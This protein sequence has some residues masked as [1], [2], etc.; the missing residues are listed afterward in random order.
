MFS[1]A[2]LIG[3]WLTSVI[4]KK[5]LMGKYEDSLSELLPCHKKGMWVTVMRKD[6]GQAVAKACPLANA[7]IK[8]LFM[9]IYIPH[10]L[11]LQPKNLNL[12]P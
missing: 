8:Q 12:G 3:E 6:V 4:L 7:Q 10:L 1:V 5:Y 9:S 2:Q 11:I